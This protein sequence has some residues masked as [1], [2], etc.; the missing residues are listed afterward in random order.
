M[1]PILI[2]RGNGDGPARRSVPDLGPF[3]DTVNT[4]AAV[5]HC[6]CC[7]REAAHGGYASL[8]APARA[9]GSALL[10]TVAIGLVLGVSALRGPVEHQT[11]TPSDQ[12]PAGAVTS[13]AGREEITAPVLVQ[14]LTPTTTVPT[15][16]H[17]GGYSDSDAAR[18][19]SSAPG[20]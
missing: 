10:G 5:C 6:S 19:G 17:A 8:A 11:R 16:D 9:L 4:G 12:I 20:G 15:R 13:T 2:T 7:V 18:P 14:S 1:T 3:A